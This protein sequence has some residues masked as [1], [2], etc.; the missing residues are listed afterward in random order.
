M[1]PA[2]AGHR[3]SSPRA[4]RC[5]SVCGAAV[6]RQAR[7]VS[8]VRTTRAALQASGATCAGRPSKQTFSGMAPSLV[9]CPAVHSSRCAARSGSPLAANASANSSVSGVHE[10][11]SR[12]QDSP[13]RR[14]PA[15]PR[16]ASAAG[17]SRASTSASGA[18]SFQPPGRLAPRLH[19]AMLPASSPSPAPPPPP[20]ERALW[21]R[22]KGTLGSS[23]GT[24]TPSGGSSTS[25]TI[26]A[27]CAERPAAVSRPDDDGSPLPSLR[28]LSAPAPHDPAVCPL[29]R[30]AQDPDGARVPSPALRAGPRRGQ[31][32]LSRAARRT[33]T[34]PECPFDGAR[35]P[36][37]RG[38]SALSTGGEASRRGGRRGRPGASRRPRPRSPGGRQGSPW[39]P[40][41]R[42]RSRRERAPSRDGG[43]TIP[44]PR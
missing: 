23:K 43:A 7:S 24:L 37:R 25:R 26:P 31:S 3:R 44:A 40:R 30:C 18:G 15:G 16:K 4:E 8:S 28:P 39:R 32:A 10:I 42:H 13:G 21:G 41:R 11:P 22:R 6:R 27:M 2:S 20:V 9:R 36:F 38:Q 29:P 1:N 19:P 35:V 34:T 33:Q 12:G 5:L 14:P 17:T